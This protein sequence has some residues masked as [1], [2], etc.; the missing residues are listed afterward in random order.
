MQDAVLGMVVLACAA[1]ATP[2]GSF[3]AEWCTQMSLAP[4]AGVAP[5][6]V[7]A[8][9]GQVDALFPPAAAGAGADASAVFQAIAPR[10]LAAYPA[11]DARYLWQRIVWL[12]CRH[13]AVAGALGPVARMQAIDRLGA[14]FYAPP[15][16]S[17]A[18]HAD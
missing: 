1:L 10:V 9:D 14:A 6:M 16:P 3:A 11:A 7:R 15:P 12:L 2:R 13:I 17:T 4:P 8:W 18:F 5:E